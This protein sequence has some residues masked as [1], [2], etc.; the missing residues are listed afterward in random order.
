[1]KKLRSDAYPPLII[2]AGS[3][4][5]IVASF[6]FQHPASKILP[7]F[8]ASSVFVLAAFQLRSEMSVKRDTEPAAVKHAVEPEGES[9][10]GWHDYWPIA[11]WI[12]GYALII[13]LAGFV[14]A[15]PLFILFYMKSHGS[16][17]LASI[18]TAFLFTGIVYSVFELA[19]R[20]ILYR[21]VLL[22]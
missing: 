4:A 13:Y 3:L 7:L 21:G 14:L 1:M 19:F 8:A 11:S 9:K 15:V 17:W 2:M 16:G 18:T 6:G 22:M 20:I 5:A 10:A 12:G